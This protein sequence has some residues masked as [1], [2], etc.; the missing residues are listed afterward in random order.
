[1]KLGKYHHV[2][3]FI[4]YINM[5]RILTK[6]KP[7]RWSTVDN[8]QNPG[9]QQDNSHTSSSYFEQDINIPSASLINLSLN[10]STE[11]DA[12]TSAHNIQQIQTDVPAPGLFS[13]L[14]VIH[15]SISSTLPSN[16]AT[17]CQRKEVI[18]SNALRNRPI[19]LCCCVELQMD[20]TFF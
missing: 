1:M 16:A 20:I 5:L 6:K 19:S 18:E 4:V 9:D 15:P 17:T 3:A 13:S 11:S 7:N 12:D 10:S 14:V 8:F 2:P